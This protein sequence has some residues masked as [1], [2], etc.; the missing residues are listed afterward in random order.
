MNLLPSLPTDNL[1][2]FCAI[3]G[4]VI[5]LFVGYTTWQKWSELRQRV[6]S[7]EAEGDA[8]K[9]SVGWWQ[10]LEK[11][12]SEALKNFA[13]N[14]PTMPTIM[15][16]GDPIPRDHFWN[17]LDSREKEIENGRLKIVDTM[18][19]MKKIMSLE[20]EMNWML[21]VGGGTVVFG[22]FL[23]GYGFLNWRSIQLKQDKVLEMEL[24]K[25]G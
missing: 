1:Y 13:K 7:L 2:K 14:D 10:I 9:L 5:V 4:I 18:A 22:F 21:W 19:T 15:L 24:K 12:R 25:Y 11:E 3:S 16:N 8:V 17:Y 23:M 20:Q 6:E